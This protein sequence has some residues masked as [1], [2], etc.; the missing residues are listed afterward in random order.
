M[1]E[2]SMV[3]GGASTVPAAAATVA[4]TGA[5]ATGAKAGGGGFA[6]L[7]AGAAAPRAG[8]GA[9]SGTGSA[10]G[11]VGDAASQ[12][13]TDGAPGGTG[14]AAAA[15]AAL[16]GLGKRGA[17]AASL[18]ASR[19]ALAAGLRR[20]ELAVRGRLSEGGVV[21]AGAGQAVTTAMADRVAA[22]LGRY[23][24]R[25]DAQHGTDAVA[26]LEKALSAVTEAKGADHAAPSSRDRGSAPDPAALFAMLSAL[27][28]LVHP[29]AVAIDAAR[30]VPVSG[31]AGGAD[32]KMPAVP[33]ARQDRAL[34][35]F[36][37]PRMQRL[38]STLLAA[39]QGDKSSSAALA[40]VARSGA[41][42]ASPVV[43]KAA[44]PATTPPA[45]PGT[46]DHALAGLLAATFGDA[47]PAAG[48]GMPAAQAAGATPAATPHGFAALPPGIS[49]ARFAQFV[50]GQIR[51]V[52]IG[53]GQ[54]RIALSPRGLGDIEI[55]LRHH[56]DGAL[57]VVVRA[58]NPVVLASLRS[59][60]E[61]LAQILAGNGLGGAGATLDFEGFAGHEGRRGQQ[62]TGRH[63]SSG[64]P[65]AD[66]AE[67]V[68]PASGSWRA[69]I[70]NGRLD[71][72]T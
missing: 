28:G 58:D 69:Q 11:A 17:D 60:R 2:I 29:R 5:K 15:L 10:V 20:G 52:T 37:D 42:V 19:V 62:E 64:A 6:A 9:S 56:D 49:Q 45:L 71:I 7:L 8:A 70:G 30:T 14:E 53:Q 39:A 25:F 68:A 13:G 40:A 38:L 16:S 3:T 48:G 27:Y 51:G 36:E 33:G 31:G 4:S 55:D 1:A 57:R 34:A 32:D 12:A 18:L 24:R 61:T 43:A 23:L 47:S 22:G 67:A 72:R 46:R 63:P 50:T 21:A 44:D 59:D 35:G 26:R 65:M 54:T 66:S 41:A